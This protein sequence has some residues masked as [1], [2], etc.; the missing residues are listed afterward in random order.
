[1][2]KIKFKK[3]K[4]VATIGPGCNNKTTLS[5]LIR[6]GVNVFRINFSHATYDEVDQNVELIR[7]LNDELGSN[8][9][10]L[11]D[12][13]GPKI[14]VGKMEDGVIFKK[15]DLFTLNCSKNLVGNK[16]IASLSYKDFAKDVNKGDKVLIDDGK[17]MFEVISTN[18]KDE[19]KLKNLQGGLLS[20]KKGVNLPNTK[21]STPS[22]T[23]KDKA[24]LT[25]AINKE[26]DWIALSSVSYTHLTLP[27]KR[28][29]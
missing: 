14:R 23:K 29:V 3:T 28:I 26:L 12:L 9:A 11:A 13:Q 5:K 16:E 15:G 8:V 22:L 18:K 6:A 19:V 17:L 25:Y 27:T 21:I 20:S 7:N 1:M 4:I 2:S 10:I 24:D